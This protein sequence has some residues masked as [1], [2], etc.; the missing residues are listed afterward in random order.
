MT[1]V[2]TTYENKSNDE[3]IALLKRRDC[4]IERFKIMKNKLKICKK[5]LEMKDKDIVE[6]E[7]KIAYYKT[8]KDVGNVYNTEQSQDTKTFRQLISSCVLPKHR[9]LLKFGLEETECGGQ[10]RSKEKKLRLSH[11]LTLS[12]RLAVQY[13]KDTG[14]V[15]TRFK[16]QIETDDMVKGKSGMGNEYPEYYKKYIEDYLAEHPVTT[17]G[18]LPECIEYNKDDESKLN[19]TCCNTII[20][21]KSLKKHL[22]SKSHEKYFSAEKITLAL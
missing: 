20:K 14:K 13:K 9:H 19:C 2:Y 8:L 22:K 3:L 17:W 7:I 15:P 10:F 6:L 18:S 11:Y 5:K 16:G 1:T 21:S 12:K 4:Q